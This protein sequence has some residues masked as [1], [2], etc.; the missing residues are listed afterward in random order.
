MSEKIVGRN[1]VLELLRS[2]NKREIERLL[3]GQGKVDPRLR[4]II[5]IAEKKTYPLRFCATAGIGSD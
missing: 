2:S 3:I 5:S 1:S 4:Q